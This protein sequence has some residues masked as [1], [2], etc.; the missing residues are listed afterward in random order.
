M[1]YTEDKGQ[2][3]QGGMNQ[4]ARNWTLTGDTTACHSPQRRPYNTIRLADR[5][6]GAGRVGFWDPGMFRRKYIHLNSSL[7]SLGCVIPPMGMVSLL[8]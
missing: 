4:T 6:V 1:N 3:K 8:S 5:V 2:N 7:M